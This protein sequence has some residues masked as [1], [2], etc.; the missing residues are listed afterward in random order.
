M[1]LGTKLVTS[2]LGCGLIPLAAV[3]Y[4]S[5][6][7]ADR[8]MSSIEQKGS[9][10]LEKKVYDQLV[11][12]REVKKTQ[13]EQYFS[14]RQGD[15]GVLIE[16]VKTL[17]SEAFH[18]LVA[19]REIKRT[20]VERY[21]QLI[22][23]Q[24]RSFSEDLMVVEAM[25][26]FREAAPNFR[27][28]NSL[29]SDDLR[30]MRR[31]LLTYYTG[32][33]TSE[34]KK[35]N[36]GKSPSAEAYFNKLDDDSI[37]LQHAFI[38]ANSHP[39]GSKHLLDTPGDESSYSELHARMHPVLRSYL[40]KFGY[41]DIFLADP[42]SGDIVYSVFKEL[43]YSTSLINGPYADTNFGEAFRRANQ[44]GNKDAVVLVDYACYAPSYEAP[45]SFIASPI[46]DGD[47]KIGIALFQMPIDRLIAI[48]SERSGLGK[49]G[50][51]YLVGS[52]RLMRSDSFL[53]PE[54]HTVLASFKDPVKGKVDTK[55]ATKGLAGE[56]GAGVIMDYTGSPVLSAWSPVK[57]GESTWCLLAEIDVA[58]AFA[59][60]ADGS[61]KDFFTQ[62]KELYGYYDLFLLNPD[63]YC[64]YTV[65]QEADYQTNLVDGKYK[66]SNL[67]E[68]VRDVLRS[69]RFGFA[70]FK[71]YAPSNGEPAAFIAQP[72]V[73]NGQT[74]IVVA[75]QLS[76]EAING[77][78][79]VRAGLGETGETILVGPD[80]LM[81]SDSFRDPKNHS[82]V[83]SFRNP[84][85]GKVKT[86]ATQSAIERGEDGVGVITDYIGN[87]ALIAYGPINVFGTNWCLNAKM[88]S[89]EAFAAVVEM[90]QTATA[91]GTSL[92]TWIG[93]LGAIAAV[94]VTFISI[95]IARSISKPINRAI[96]G[97]NEGAAQVNDAAGQVSSTSQQLA[98]GASE[99]ASS[100]EETSSALEEMA[101]M[102]KTNAT[103]AKQANEL[104]N[105]ARTA[106]ESGNET[107]DRL[108][109]AMTAINES[110]G[111]ISKIIKVIE[112]IAFQ[113]N[114]LAL[115]AAVEAARAGEHGK[116]FAVVADEVRNLAQRAAQ[117]AGETTDLIED[118][119]NR[120]REGSE[121]ACEVADSLGK[122]VTDVSKVSDLI[123]GITKASEEQAQ[124]VEQVN[125]AVSQMDKV[126]QSNASGAEESAS[127]SE[128]LA[129][130]SQAVKAM[131]DELAAVIGGDR[132]GVAAN[133]TSHE[134]ATRRP[135]TRKG[136]PLSGRKIKH[137]AAAPVGAVASAAHGE[138]H[139]VS[140]HPAQ[141]DFLPMDTEDTKDF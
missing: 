1:T 136:A 119:V 107:M 79:G 115:N 7:S 117:A 49:T 129:S 134:V 39:L 106:A 52:D 101:A 51:T 48:M 113:T 135:A 53:D 87:E 57:V 4:V 3:A 83:S 81:R 94:F 70:D 56:T 120:A 2:F 82:V 105:Q 54:H 80:Y 88:D 123:D 41:Y 95:Y 108:N 35:Q 111:K 125:T 63:G 43:D 114:L 137:A 141:D 22:D 5:Y 18:K 58:E 27:A 75:L 15:M 45:A 33:F 28:E 59:P 50:E 90:K 55:A 96:V 139:L 66:D 12:L 9:A 121:V 29:S 140:Q 34:F 98:E 17:R 116:G 10:D 46:F 102:T 100:L 74:E 61:D 23:N 16:T 20:A 132:K 97:L 30:R 138:Q 128:E 131:V 13:L 99:Q 109:A 25:R 62:Y 68:L 42:D 32:D 130:Q 72:V 93:S 92:L 47:R 69:G 122:I 6:G 126:T 64:F 37:A 104:S 31:E 65:T 73:H 21:F 38:R 67:G 8:G 118:S 124:G 19:V 26:G 86:D 76:L 60:K 14:E 40:E 78:M 91:A 36:G 133:A 71:P 77:I 44:A 127:A 103:N 89:A 24:I 112:E 11:A 84:S 110:S 85:T